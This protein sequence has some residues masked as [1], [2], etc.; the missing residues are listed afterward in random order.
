[1]R[2]L[3]VV[4]PVGSS[5]GFGLNC[6]KRIGGAGGGSTSRAATALDPGRVSMESMGSLMLMFAPTA[7]AA[8]S[9]SSVQDVA[10]ASCPPVKRRMPGSPPSRPQAP[11]QPELTKLP[12]TAVMPAG[13]SSRKVMP[14]RASAPLGLAREK[15]SVETSPTRSSSAKKTLESVG[16][17]G[18]SPGSAGVQIVPEPVKFIR[19]IRMSMLGFAAS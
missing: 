12:P 17:S 4:E 13:S 9:T 6:L 7:V 11:P 10:A 8:T 15:L 1:M 18:A 19:W 3:K 2:K 16:G 14:L 5:S